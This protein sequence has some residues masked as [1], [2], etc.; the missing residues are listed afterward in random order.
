MLYFFYK[1][2]FFKYHRLVDIFRIFCQNRTLKIYLRNLRNRYPQNLN[3]LLLHL[4]F[5]FIVEHKVGEV[6]IL[7]ERVRKE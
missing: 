7:T 4:F 6:R 5:N 1:N 2:L 3:D